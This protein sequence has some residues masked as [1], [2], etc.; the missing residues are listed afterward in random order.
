MDTVKVRGW[1]VAWDAR[2]CLVSHKLWRIF[3][4][5][6]WGGAAAFSGASVV[7][8]GVLWLFAAIVWVWACVKHSHVVT[9][10]RLGATQ[11]FRRFGSKLK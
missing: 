10:R 1:C 8:Y 9:L 2:C 3:V 5:V 4:A 11:L 6:R 7:F